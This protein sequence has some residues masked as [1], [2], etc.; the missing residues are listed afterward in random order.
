MTLLVG[1]RV[2]T[3]GG[4]LDPGWVEVGGDRIVGVGAGSGRSGGMDLGGGWLLPGFIDLHV[5]GGGGHDF[6]TSPE[7]LAAGVAFHA[8]HGTTRT[9]VSLVTGPIEA[10]RERLGWVADAVGLGGSVVGAHLEGPFLSHARCGAQNPAYLI[11]PDQV[12]LASF[13][14]AGRGAVRMVTV[15]PELPGGLEL[16]DQLVAAGV[17]A[18]VGHTDAD[19]ATTRLAF[20]RGASLVTHAF[21]GMRSTHHREP[22]AVP[23]ALDAGVPC[24]LINDGVH[25]HPAAARLLLRGAAE[26]I[27][28]IT[29]AIDAT[30]VGDGIYTLGGQ[31][32][33][34]QAGQARLASNDSLAGSTLTMD[35]AVRR[36]V[37][38]VG[39]SVAAASLAASGTPARLLGLADRCGALT[40]G[41]DADLVH[42]DD[43]LRLTRVMAAGRWLDATPVWTVETER[44]DTNAKFPH[45]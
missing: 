2:V 14:E 22:G 28:L 7:D 30:G 37:C 45:P 38:D 25:V 35:V 36:A 29:D 20:D 4:V 34:V 17:L 21:N 6:T 32:V 44:R 23:A 26:T 27:V 13:L 15:A 39:M 12:V 5:H 41:L 42:L 24:E 18:A 31:E 3:P 43:D 10:T 19:Y 8:A 40:E 9:L 33:V 1:V 16:I 11:E